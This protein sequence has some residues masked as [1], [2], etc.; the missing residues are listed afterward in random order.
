MSRPAALVAVVVPLATHVCV[1]SLLEPL[2][3]GRQFRMNP[4]VILFSLG[5]W[6]ILWGSIGAVLAVPLTSILRIVCAYLLENKARDTAEIQPRYSRD[7]A[8]I[9]PTSRTPTATPRGGTRGVFLFSTTCFFSDRLL[10][11]VGQLRQADAAPRRD[12]ARDELRREPRG[13]GGR[14]VG[15]VQR[16]E[17]SMMNHHQ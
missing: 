16:Q 6:Y 5:V 10:L 12:G 4:V 2:L 7:T 17:Q 11:A 13:W 9:Q 8:E 15:L 14:G 3:F 1:G